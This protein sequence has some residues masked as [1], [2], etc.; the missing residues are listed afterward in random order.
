M[1]T[2]Q[3]GIIGAGPAGL[4]LSHLLDRVGIDSVILEDRTRE[5]V[6]AR[7]RAGV[8]EHGTVAILEDL[9]LA[10]R[11]HR[12]G[13]EHHGVALQFNGVRHRIDFQDLVGTSI[14]VYGQQEVVKDLIAAREAKGHPILFGAEV[15]EISG[16]EDWSPESTP[17]AKFTLDGVEDTLECDLLIGADGF[18]G[19]SRRAIPAEA[20]SI[21]ERE[22]PF[23]WLGILAEVEPSSDE[24]LYAFHERGFAM[25]SMRSPRISRLYLQVD[26][27]DDIA[28]WPDERI[29]EELQIRLA[30]PGWTLKE[31]PIIEKGITPMR[32]F[33][34][35]PMSYGKL[36]LAG[37][38]AHI[39]PPTGAKGLNLAVA[40]IQL[41]A[42][43]ITLWVDKGD[44]SGLDGYSE[45]ALERVWRAQ[46]FSNMMTT[47]LH[48]M[49]EADEFERKIQAARQNFVL[50][51][52]AQATALAENYVGLPY[53]W[54][55]GY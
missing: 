36:F 23:G 29:W 52:R 7:I 48:V 49:T 14:W 25:H 39:V 4:F 54:P 1:I 43:A 38:A 8:L 20:L 50:N 21:Y 17:Q 18:Y 41:L 44:R 40:D 16:F 31:G 33:V 22:Y 30:T 45:R 5:Y 37:D 3:V 32:S 27:H 55:K 13:L 34:A 6:E 35:E 51:S 19:P 15:T 11:L 53:D 10:D 9:G 47:M 42:R 46:D 12:E 28:N 2:T 24:V 26:P